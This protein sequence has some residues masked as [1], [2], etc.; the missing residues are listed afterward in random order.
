VPSVSGTVQLAVTTK[1]GVELRPIVRNR[2]DRAGEFTLLGVN[3]LS[4]GMAGPYVPI[5]T[6]ISVD[7][8]FEDVLDFEVRE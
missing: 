2:G 8:P 1:A 6:P 7:L 3:I 4:L 5:G